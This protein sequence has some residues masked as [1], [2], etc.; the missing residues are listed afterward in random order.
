[1]KEIQRKG[2]AIAIS[3]VAIK[4]KTKVKSNTGAIDWLKVIVKEH[5]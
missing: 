5:F 1:M 3:N 4:I 2:T